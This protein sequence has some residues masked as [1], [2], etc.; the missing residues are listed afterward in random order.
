[1]LSHAQ[2]IEDSDPQRFPR[3]T[4]HHEGTTFE[5]VREEVSVRRPYSCADF[6]QYL[7]VRHSQVST[8]ATLALETLRV[9]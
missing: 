9:E 3:W 2:T 7:V 8:R 1:M 6:S 5:Y 4:L